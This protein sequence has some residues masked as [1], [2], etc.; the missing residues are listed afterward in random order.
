MP[1]IS[2]MDRASSRAV[3]SAAVGYPI[4]EEKAR[5]LQQVFG[6]LATALPEHRE[7]ASE[8]VAGRS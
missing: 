5:L 1:T 4:E 8:P 3:L 2:S 6:A 7:S